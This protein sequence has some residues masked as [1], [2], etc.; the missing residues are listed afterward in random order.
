MEGETLGY[1][2]PR[3]KEEQLT[4]D[5]EKVAAVNQAEINLALD[6]VEKILLP[7]KEGGYQFSDD[8]NIHATEIQELIS[9]YEVLSR[10]PREDMKPYRGRQTLLEVLLGLRGVNRKT[11]TQV[12]ELGLRGRFFGAKRTIPKTEKDYKTG[13]ESS[14]DAISGHI[15]QW[16]KSRLFEDSRVSVALRKYEKNHGI[17]RS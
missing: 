9:C 3:P 14:D 16:L 8:P 17:I 12:P 11:T 2:P 4:N 10:A 15:Y 13:I 6:H 5:V 7:S 1:T